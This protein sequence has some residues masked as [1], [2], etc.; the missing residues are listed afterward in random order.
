MNR[1]TK[2][3]LNQINTFFIVL[4]LIINPKLSYAL[5]EKSECEKFHTGTFV[6]TGSYG[7][8]II[9]RNK[10]YEINYRVYPHSYVRSSIKWVSPCVAESIAV[11]IHDDIFP[12]EYKKIHLKNRYKL[13]VT[14]T[15]PD[16]YSYK[17]TE[18]NSPKVNYGK[19]KVYEGKLQ[20]K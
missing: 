20:A 16:G 12:D 19:V 4:V 5:N 11:E 15:F 7:D 6:Y 8:V 9:V 17:L 18:E 3:N 13:Y 10:S 1:W 14:E 2:L